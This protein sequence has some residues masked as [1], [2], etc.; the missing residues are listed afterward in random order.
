MT[1]ARD[2]RSESHFASFPPSFSSLSSSFG[3][4]NTC[5][6]PLPPFSQNFTSFFSIFYW[7]KKISRLYRNDETF[8]CFVVERERER[9]V[10]VWMYFESYSSLQGGEREKVRN[11]KGCF[12]RKYILS[13]IFVCEFL[14]RVCVC[15]YMYLWRDERPKS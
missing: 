11:S 7:K 15:V 1:K 5:F 9:A 10:L 8:I 4:K 12:F 2:A 6:H 13:C 3:N 14:L